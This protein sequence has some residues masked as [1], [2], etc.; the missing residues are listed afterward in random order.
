MREI[1]I[2]I[3]PKNTYAAR[4]ICPANRC[5]WIGLKWAVSQEQDEQK[6]EAGSH[7]IDHLK[8]LGCI[9]I[10]SRTISF[11]IFQSCYLKLQL[12]YSRLINLLPSD[13]DLALLQQQESSLLEQS[14]R[15]HR[16]LMRK[17]GF[18]YC[19]LGVAPMLGYSGVTG[20]MLIFVLGDKLTN[21]FLSS[22]Y[23][24]D[25]FVLAHLDP[26]LSEHEL[27]EAFNN[28]F[29]RL[30][31]LN[32]KKMHSIMSNLKHSVFSVVQANQLIADLR[33]QQE[34]LQLLLM[35]KSTI[36]PVNRVSSWRQ[37]QSRF[38]L[39]FYLLVTI[40]G[41]ALGNMTNYSLSEFIYERFLERGETPLYFME[42]VCFVEVYFITI[43]GFEKF[44]SPLILLAINLRDK[45]MFLRTIEAKIKRLNEL[46]REL[47]REMNRDDKRNKI[48]QTGSRL[49]GATTKNCCRLDSLRIECDHEALGIYLSLRVFLDEL[50]ATTD[51]ASLILNQYC[52]MALGMLMVT[53]PFCANTDSQQL[54]M[55][56]FVLSNFV[57]I[58]DLA[59]LV[60]ARFESTCVQTLQRSWSLV[61]SFTRPVDEGRA[62]VEPTEIHLAERF[63]RAVQKSLQPPLMN[64]SHQYSRD[65]FSLNPSGTSLINEHTAMLWRRFSIDMQDLYRS[66]N[67]R[68]FGAIRLNYSG[69]L[70]LN[71][72]FISVVLIF[73]SF[74]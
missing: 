56:G 59:I 29:K 17:L 57:T 14:V 32:N 71:F 55:L 25:K 5:H 2:Q 68:I 49:C 38:S 46:L 69:M 73:L 24:A 47:W 72:W 8:T 44:A 39:R 60:C 20:I 65:Y 48:T 31:M 50:G 21:S 35:D 66:L 6:A 7:W 26:T 70:R 28:Y 12:D 13:P 63:M 22:K 62:L 40:L 67:C 30:I 19:E 37:E 11:L 64:Y 33:G 45:Q 61:A 1:R 34:Q 4:R 43:L 27:N 52:S 15:E 74:S 23:R 16:H 58:I 41:F 18:N 54:A 51:L 53:V 9:Y 42:R 10:L 3:P 36:W